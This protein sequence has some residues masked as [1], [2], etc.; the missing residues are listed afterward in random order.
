MALVSASAAALAAAQ[1]PT[2]GPDMATAAPAPPSAPSKRHTTTSRRRAPTSATAPSARA[3]A[4]SSSTSALQARIERNVADA[5]SPPHGPAAA[6]SSA[7]QAAA[8]HNAKAEADADLTARGAGDRGRLKVDRQNLLG[9]A[10]KTDLLRQG[11]GPP[12]Y[13]HSISMGDKDHIEQVTRYR[14][15]IQKPPAGQ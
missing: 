10:A 3:P 15:Y 11:L 14:V 12:N 1:S 2:T 9:D 8:E 7:A 5:A 6:A 4:D 13:D